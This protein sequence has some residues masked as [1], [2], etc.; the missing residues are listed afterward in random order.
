MR[1]KHFSRV[2]VLVYNILAQGLWRQ[3]SL[4]RASVPFKG[5]SKTDWIVSL[6]TT[7]IILKTDSV[8]YRFFFISWPTLSSNRNTLCYLYVMRLQD[9]FDLLLGNYLVEDH[10]EGPSPFAR[11]RPIAP[12]TVRMH[13]LCFFF[14]IT[15]W[16]TFSICQVYFCVTY[17]YS[18]VPCLSGGPWRFVVVVRFPSSWR[19]FSEGLIFF[20]LPAGTSVWYQVLIVLFWLGALLASVKVIL[21]YGHDLVDKPQ[22][23]AQD[24]N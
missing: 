23:C 8:R 15:F 13:P 11:Y 14:V 20:V 22:L 10:R 2:G 21:M 3:I 6:G 24:H 19:Y 5:P 12:I 18:H 16:Q 1:T 4:E 7:S 9:A 17:W